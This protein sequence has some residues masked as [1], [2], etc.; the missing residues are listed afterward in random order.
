MG[1]LNDNL[2]GWRAKLDT[3]GWGWDDNDHKSRKINEA[4]MRAKYYG[5]KYIIHRPALRYALNHSRSVSTPQGQ[6]SESPTTVPGH[7]SQHASP[8]LQHNHPT[9]TLLRRNSEMG[10][11]RRTSETLDPRIRQAAEVC[12][13]AAIRSTTVFDAVSGRLIITNIFGT[14]HA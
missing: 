5:A 6:L 11:P 10:P 9:T 8:A 7:S 2:E 13:Q 3:F 4:R 14:A 1:I 12:I